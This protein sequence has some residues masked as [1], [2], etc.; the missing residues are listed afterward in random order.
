MVPEVPAIVTVNAPWVAVLLAVSVSTLE[1]AEDVGLNAAVTPLGSPVA[2]KVTLPVNPPVSVTV[3]VSVTVPLCLRDTEDGEGVRLK[4]AAVNALTVRAMVVFAV[5]LPEVP[6]MV[7]VTDPPTVAVLL[8]VNVSTVEVADEVGLNEAVTPLGR[9]V[10]AN[11]G[12]PVNPSTSVTEIVSVAVLPCV[13]ESVDAE[14]AS[15]NV[16]VPV[17]ELAPTKVTILCAGSV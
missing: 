14:G 10:T 12:L 3:I 4:P 15:V 6:V 5:V 9:P 7:T 2:V 16:G 17:P 1:V 13:T 8:A 11:D